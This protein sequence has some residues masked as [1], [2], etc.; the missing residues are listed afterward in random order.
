MSINGHKLAGIFQNLARPNLDS[1]E[2]SPVWGGL[3]ILS[4]LVGFGV[5][6]LGFL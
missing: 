4:P 5:P 3:Y 6:C 2:K 1:V